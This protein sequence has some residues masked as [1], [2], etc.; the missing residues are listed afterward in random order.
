MIGPITAF[1]IIWIAINIVAYCMGQ[2]P[3]IGL[4]LLSCVLQSNILIIFRSQYLGTALL[5]TCLFVVIKIINNNSI[6]MTLNNKTLRRYVAFFAYSFFITI[7]AAGLLFRGLPVFTSTVLYYNSYISLH[8]TLRS[9]YLIGLLSVYLV[10]AILIYKYCD[11]FSE[12]DLVRTVEGISVFVLTVGGIVYIIKYLGI[13]SYLL[14]TLLYSQ[15]TSSCYHDNVV[16][17]YSTFLEPSYSSVY[18]A[19][20]FWFRM[21]QG[22][23]YNKIVTLGILAGLLLSLGMTGFGAFAV[24]AV[25]F[26]LFNRDK[27]ILVITLGIGIIALFVL[28]QTGWV[29]EI[30]DQLMSKRFSATRLAWNKYAL[31]VFFTTKGIGVGIGAARANSLVINIM[32]KTGVI[33]LLLYSMAMFTELKEL[34]KKKALNTAY[35]GTFMYVV[36]VLAGQIIGDPDFEFEV[37]WFGLFIFAI[38]N[39][40]KSQFGERE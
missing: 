9:L 3:L 32:A 8:I 25:V 31:E 28:I 18:F 12:K 4:L 38:I 22:D 39:G 29:Q 27:K 2:K 5:V 20:L 15:P 33:G 37:F 1:S 6:S 35:F 11:T 34:L 40:E 19:A 13:S 10:T 17:F 7:L 14:A 30:Y 23:K 36:T 16:R 26:M 24:A 21:V